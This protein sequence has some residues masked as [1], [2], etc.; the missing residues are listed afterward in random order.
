MVRVGAGVTVGKSRVRMSIV[1]VASTAGVV[2]GRVAVIVAA[3]ASRGPVRLAGSGTT[4][5]GVVV[6]VGAGEYVSS[7]DA[8]ICVAVATGVDVGVGR[9]RVAVG[10][11]VAVESSVAVRVALWVAVG[12]AIN[13]LSV[14]GKEAFAKASL[15]AC[16]AST[17]PSNNVIRRTATVSRVGQMQPM[18]YARRVTRP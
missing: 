17:R 12:M 9:R 3:G 18:P 14:E 11:L 8:A 15:P 5:V 7:G 6:M 2:V 1:A 13:W 16:E 10:V 4:W